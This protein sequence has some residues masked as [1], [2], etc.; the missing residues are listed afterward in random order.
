[1]KKI[2]NTIDKID[3]FGVPV[4]L[5]TN[6]KDLFYQ[7][8]LGGI[9]TLFVGS[10]GFAYFLY[11]IILWIENHLPPNVSFKQ[12]TLSYAEF[13]ITNSV[14]QLELQD[15]SGEVDPFR[16][17]NNII[18][19]Y[20]YKIIDR[21][22][23]DKPIPLFSSEDKPFIISIDNGTIVLNHD[24]SGQNGRFLMTQY[25]LVFQSCSDSLLENGSYCA[26]ESVINEYLSK[27]HGFLFLSIK[28]HQLNYFTRQLEEF[29]K[30]Y[31]TAFQLT[32]PLY[33][34]VMLKQQETIIDDGILFNNY[35]NYYFLN[36]YELI[37]QEVEN[38]FTSN[39]VSQMSQQNYKFNNFGCYLFRIDDISISENVTMPKLG[40][41]LAQVG[42]IVQIIFMLK[43]IALYYNKVLLENELLHEIITMYYPE[44]KNIKLNFLNQFEFKDNSIKSIKNLNQDFKYKYKIF[45]K[46]AKVKCRLNNILYEISRIQFIL[47]QQFGDQLLQ[48][49]HQMGSR[50]SNNYI[51]YEHCKDSNRLTVKPANSLDIDNDFAL[52][53]P[54]EILQKQP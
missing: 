43:Y 49:S 15:F 9:V 34:Q 26:N 31:Y 39:V 8:K 37:N 21:T 51:D 1:M 46:R 24:Y 14:I 11:V 54:L 38:S 18:T 12:Q 35:Q 16:R 44:M 52:L 40:Q 19:P 17:E 13:E 5:L 3:I 42:S 53:E 29:K 28:L 47:Q 41:V 7:S 23:I 25:L 6:S 2:L 20:L 48:Q 50:L 32:K 4:N 33:S 36:N 22:I 10:L 45:L 30:Q 27:F